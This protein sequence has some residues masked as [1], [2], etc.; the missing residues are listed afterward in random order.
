[1]YSGLLLTFIFLIF[2]YLMMTRRM[3][4]LLALPAMALT[5]GA[6]A[7]IMY[8]CSGGS[9]SLRSFL[10]DTVLTQG[11]V[12]LSQAIMFTVFGSILSQVVMRSGIAA[13]LI[14][15]TAEYAGQHKLRLAFLLTLM[16]AV[17]FTSV[18]G[19]GAVIM[20]GTLV[21]PI[22]IGSGLSASFSAGL[23]LFAIALGGVFNPAILGFYTDVLQLSQTVVKQY[24]IYYGSFLGLAALAYLTVG[25]LKERN[26]FNWAETAEIKQKKLPAIS[27]VTPLIPIL[28]IMFFNVPIIP[29][30]IAGILWGLLSTNLKGFINELSAAVLEGIKDVAPVLGLFVGL[31]MCLN[32]MMAEPVKA[33]MAPMLEAVLPTSPWGFVFFFLILAPLALYRGPLNMYGLGAGVAGIIMSGSLLAP[34]AVMAAFFSVGQMQGVCDPTN[35][36]N[37]WLGQFA[38]VSTGKLLADTMPYVWGFVAVSLI[39]AVFFNGALQM[40]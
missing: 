34:T 30:F 12:K 19:L 32:A 21:M 39:W 36:H 29:A 9:L 25:G 37:V 4:A 16:T 24:V 40:P 8:K 17:C 11:S 35:T 15:L 22:L 7:G 33:V 13:R 14:G 27:L 18:T 38:K 2:A 6:A 1:M 3:P 20:I 31:G 28:L 10:F 5:V 23:M 26:T